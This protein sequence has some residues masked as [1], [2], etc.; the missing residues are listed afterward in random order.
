MS[1]LNNMPPDRAISWLQAAADLT[2]ALRELNAN[3]D[4]EKMALEAHALP[5]R[6]MEKAQKARDDIKA[7]EEKISDAEATMVQMDSYQKQLNAQEAALKKRTA[8]LDEHAQKLNALKRQLE[9]KATQQSAIAEQ[10][11]SARDAV[12]E[13]ESALNQREQ[14]LKEREKALDARESDMK[15]RA[16]RLQELTKGL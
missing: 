14:Q 2:L 12:D 7:W 11:K 16:A 10:L 15:E 6:E 13:K 8:E 1:L 9:E 3:P 5:A 4:L